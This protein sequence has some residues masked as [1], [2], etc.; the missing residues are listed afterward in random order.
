[1]ELFALSLYATVTIAMVLACFFGP[2]GKIY[3]FPFWAGIIAA[4]WFLPQAIGGYRALDQFPPGS[5]FTAMM[6]AAFCNAAMWI[7]FE[8]AKRKPVNETSWLAAD[9]RERG[10]FWAGAGMCMFGWFFQYKLYQL[11]EEVLSKGQWSGVAVIYLFLASVFQMGFVTLWLLYLS[12]RKW[13]DVRYIFFLTP[14]LWTLLGAAFLHGRRSAMMATFSY[15]FVTAWFVLRKAIPRW[16]L[17]GAVGVGLLLVNSIG[18]YRSI[19]SEEDLTLKQKFE[20]VLRADYMAESKENLEEAGAE[21]RN[22]VL[23]TALYSDTGRYD[24][25]GFHWNEFV[26]S[27][28]P[29][30]IIGREFKKSLMFETGLSARDVGPLLLEKYGYEKGVGTTMSGYADSFGSFA[31]FGWIKFLL[32]GLMMGALYRHAMAG[33]FLGQMLYVYVLSVAMHA[34]SH[35]TDRIL[36]AVWVYFLG[37]G[38]PVISR[39][40]VKRTSDE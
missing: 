16:A 30:Q 24:F 4:G 10:L 14:C 39:A 5:Y 9:F 15:L 38:Y 29:G 22:Y 25:G 8:V 32:I 20:K 28:V 36:S 26:F 6:T 11:S 23:V 35:G 18:I 3:E 1:M 21:F 34:V 2:R 7:G 33:H 12:R 37:L 40:K 19:M 17:L 27:F 13:I 31:W